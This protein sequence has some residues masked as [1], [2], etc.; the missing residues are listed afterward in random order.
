VE[1]DSCKRGSLRVYLG[2]APGVGKTYAMLD[3]A[4]RRR[5]RGVDLV[6]ALVETHGRPQTAAQLTGLE[7]V[8]RRTVEH[9]GASFTELDLDAV[10]ARR[11][12]VAIVDELAHTNVPGSQHEKRWQDVDDLL[13]AG[14]D[15]VTTVN[16]QH[17]ESLNDVVESITGVHQ[18][19]TVPD[20]VVRRADQIE[21]VDMSPEALRRRLAHGNVYGP[22][23]IDAALTHYFRAGNLT[24]LR[25]LALLWTADR[26]DDALSRYRAEHEI[27]DLWPTRERLVVAVT[28]GP[29]TETLVR[30]GVRVAGRPAGGELLVVHVTRGD[31]LAGASPDALARH[32]AFV[33][34]LGGTWHTVVGDDVATAVLDFARGVNANRILLGATRR[35]GLRAALSPGIVPRVIRG[36]GE[37][38]VLVVTHEQAG[39]GHRGLPRRVGL[40]RS[41]QV[42]AWLL[43]VIGPVVLGLV[44][45]DA[46]DLDSLPTV[47]MLFLALTVGV[48]LI[49]GLWPA[50]CA[51]IS[52]GL[53]SNYLFVPPVGTFTIAAPRNALAILV[54]VA[55]AVAVSTVVDLAARRT[56]QAAR[57]RGEADTLAT[58]A[59]SVLRG[60]D[61]VPAMLG[62]LREAFALTGVSLL[63]RPEGSTGW[64]VLHTVGDRAPTSPT[65]ATA[66]VPV[67]EG[68]TL[69]LRGRTPSA[70]DLRLVTVI[71]LHIDAALER[72]R[73]RAQ[74]R[75]TK[76]E[77]ERTAMRT[78]LLAAVSHDLRTPLAAIKAGVTAL[79]STRA[80][81]AAADRDALLADVATSTDRLQALID[82]LLD[83]SRL[84]AG[85]VSPMRAPVALDEVV[86]LAVAPLADAR[87]Q[88]DV[89]EDLPL[90]VA[91]AGLLERAVAN[92]VENALRYTDGPVRVVAEA[93]PDALVV[94]VVD[95]GLGVPDD[96]KAD[97]FTAFQRLG[98]SP[99]GHGLGLGLAVARG[100][101]EAN[102]GTLEAENTPGGGLTMVLTL[103]IG[104]A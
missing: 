53:L 96:R 31:G 29:E 67:R 75:A 32:R 6:V 15:V 94:R 102:G 72:D 69:A 101:V 63:T 48:A 92:L 28:G 9:R 68:L 84:D 59:G 61:A 44:L 54:L 83:M 20:E 11:P 18:Q 8:P 16:I 89:P 79:T 103:P 10:L 41:R 19:E 71:G 58:V 12:Q 24:A 57:A 17:L 88:L 87:L 4:R 50:L 91:D 33:E 65:D 2:A 60:E 77:R 34:S 38:D 30:R 76:T 66:A 98:D 56:A 100:F 95:S 93:L 70:E 74:A 40:S 52:S 21:L 97:V 90:V 13:A 23:R 43:S 36:S 5:E 47:L 25:E 3:E 99:H 55:V 46:F 1:T 26:V 85:V 27:A 62:Q 42:T 51:A 78:A 49:G 86:P 73:L 22:E 7:V 35:P 64:T 82:N 14:I 45:S 104:A 39:R 81:I 80:V 37:I